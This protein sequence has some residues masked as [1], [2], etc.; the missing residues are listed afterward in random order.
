MESMVQVAKGETAPFWTE[1][2]HVH[3]LNTMEASFVRTMLHRNGG[4]Y[5]SG[6]WQLLRL[7][8]HLPD[9]SESTLDSE[10]SRNSK[11]K[12]K[13]EGSPSG[14]RSRTEK[15]RSMRRRRRSSQLHISSMEEQ[16][17]PEIE[18]GGAEDTAFVGE[19]HKH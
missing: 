7:D 1:E 19:H 16:V 9:S 2:R 5:Y 13:H 17:V 15:R 12:K 6:R 4:D 11:M 10:E 8:R 18:N 3:F 14:P